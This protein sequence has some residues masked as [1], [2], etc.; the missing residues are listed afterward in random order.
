M[1][2]WG[3]TLFFAVMAMVALVFCISD[4]SV[5]MNTFTALIVRLGAAIVFIEMTVATFT[6]FCRALS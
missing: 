3:N 4:L 6:A 2:K 5:V 1:S